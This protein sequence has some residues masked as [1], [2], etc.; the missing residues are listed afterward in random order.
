MRTIATSNELPISGDQQ[1]LLPPVV[2]VWSHLVRGTSFA[3]VY[4]FD[5]ALVTFRTLRL[6]AE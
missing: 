4:D 2:W 3:L 6:V 5:D 1:L